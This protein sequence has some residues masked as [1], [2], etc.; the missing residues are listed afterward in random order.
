MYGPFAKLTNYGLSELRKLDTLDNRVRAPSTLEVVCQVMDPVTQISDHQS[1]Q[2][3]R[4]VDVSF[5]TMY[6]AFLAS[7]LSCPGD[8]WTALLESQCLFERPLS[9]LGFH[10]MM[11]NLEFKLTTRALL[12]PPSYSMQLPLQTMPHIDGKAAESYEP[13][14]TVIRDRGPAKKRQKTG[15]SGSASRP[16]STC[17]YA[18]RA[19][20][21]FDYQPQVDPSV[22][23]R[24]NHTD[25]LPEVLINHHLAPFP[26]TISRANRDHQLRTLSRYMEKDFLPL[27]NAPAMLPK[28]YVL[29]SLGSILPSTRS[30]LVRA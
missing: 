16:N 4:R 25:T 10:D 5:L 13:I 6:R 30:S 20:H 12:D 9:G 19:S 8:R 2:S 15:G 7:G 11:S 1:I 27:S 26:K 3:V 22:S 14:A 23:R 21:H 17:R 24:P 18:P 28:C 29:D